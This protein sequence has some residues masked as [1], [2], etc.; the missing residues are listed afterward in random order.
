MKLCP[1][2]TLTAWNSVLIVVP[3]HSME[4]RARFEHGNTFP[5]RTN[6]RAVLAA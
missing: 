4:L 2:L 3:Y 5:I 1:Y 6:I